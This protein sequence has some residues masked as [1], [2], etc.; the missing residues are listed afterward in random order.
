MKL[1]LTVSL[2]LAGTALSS[3]AEAQRI[4]HRVRFEETLATISKHY[5][6][7]PEHA[8]IV[9]LANGLDVAAPLKAGDHV[10]VPTAWT[11]TLR[12]AMSVDELGKQLLGDRRRG[13]VLAILNKLK[14]KKLKAGKSITVPFL[15]SHIAVSGDTYANLA[16]RFYGSEKHTALIST[17]NLATSPRPQ[18][19]APV[20]IP[21]AHVQLD[22]IRLEELV[23]EQLLGVSSRL[24]REK[25]AA[26]QEAN[27]LLRSGEYWSVPLRLA[28]LL[29]REIA[30]DEFT[31][32]VFKLLAVAY[33]ALE[34]NELAVRTFQEAL[35][36][37]PALTMDQVSTSPRVMRAYIDAKAQLQRG[38]R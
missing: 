38:N 31:A 8:A 30:S 11:Y 10:R 17:F 2:L 37:Q 13:Q 34:K 20:E 9:G 12:K 35:S 24:D 3:V 27:A 6:G 5:Y 19:G 25:R 23:S 14:K 15:L 1:S 36:R 7:S 18:V 22:P 33:V 32:E 21:I 26:L 16:R 28:Q 4:I 29:A